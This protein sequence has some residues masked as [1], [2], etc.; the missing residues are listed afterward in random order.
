[1]TI[2]NILREQNQEVDQLAHDELVLKKV[3]P[4]RVVLVETVT[5][6]SIIESAYKEI[7]TIEER[8]MTWMTP[9]ID[10]LKDGKITGWAGR[11][12]KGEG[13]SIQLLFAQ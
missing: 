5:K 11:S 1:M 4:K 2:I 13:Q 3:D 7:N 9:I 12:F 10:F 6:P 8:A